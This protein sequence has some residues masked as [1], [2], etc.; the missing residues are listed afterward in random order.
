MKAELSNFG[1][2]QLGIDIL[3]F[4]Y[5]LWCA[6]QLKNYRRMVQ[7]MTADS[8]AVPTDLALIEEWYRQYK[9]LEPETPKWIA[10]KNRLIAM[11]RIKPDEE[12]ADDG[13]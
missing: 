9:S 8:K 3:L 7:V 10:Y 4:A 13:Y 1:L 12:K 11:G 5:V 2:I 6:H